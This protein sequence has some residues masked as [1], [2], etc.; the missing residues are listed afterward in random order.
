MWQRVCDIRKKKVNFIAFPVIPGAGPYQSQSLASVFNGSRAVR[1]GLNANKQSQAD[2]RLFLL[3]AELIP[4]AAPDESDYKALAALTPHFQA[5]IEFVFS[6]KQTADIVAIC[7]GRSKVCRKAIET[8]MEKKVPSASSRHVDVWVIYT[9]DSSDSRTPKRKVA[10]SCTNRETVQVVLPDRKT[11][12]EG[13]A[14]RGVQ[15]VRR[16]LDP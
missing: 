16:K 13:P 3:S 14:S 4:P 11:T 8:F 6:V 15:S 1:V 7:D 10:F 12:F 2:T 9:P 5:A